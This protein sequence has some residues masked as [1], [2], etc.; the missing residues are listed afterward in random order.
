MI[1][2][3]RYKFQ[4]LYNSFDILHTYCT[5][6][7]VN[8]IFFKYESLFITEFTR[9]LL[10]SRLPHFAIRKYEGHGRFY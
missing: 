2:Q 6:N 9:G 4:S 10:I 5:D 8:K 3:K 1:S 7:L